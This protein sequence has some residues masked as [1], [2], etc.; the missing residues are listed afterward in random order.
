MKP[1]SRNGSPVSQ[2]RRLTPGFAATSPRLSASTDSGPFGTA[3]TADIRR[4]RLNADHYSG[5]ADVGILRG[6][7]KPEHAIT[8]TA[9]ERKPSGGSLSATRPDRVGSG[10]AVSWLAMQSWLVLEA[11]EAPPSV[12]TRMRAVVGEPD[13]ACSLASRPSS[14][15]TSSRASV[16]FDRA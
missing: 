1:W 16:A 7:A 2:Q 13:S 3:R 5:R 12:K 9:T 4:H 6:A 14:H 10:S 15:P 11:L 8:R